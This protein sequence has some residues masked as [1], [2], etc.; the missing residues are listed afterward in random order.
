MNK[1]FRFNAED[2]IK[3]DEIK[4]K[5]FLTGDMEVL[6]YCMTQ[7]WSAFSTAVSGGTPK[8]S[9]DVVYEVDEYSSAY[10][11]PQPNFKRK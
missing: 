5:L 7:V 6:R 4:T 9:D 3:L 10:K 11:A 1:T 8:S 2:Q